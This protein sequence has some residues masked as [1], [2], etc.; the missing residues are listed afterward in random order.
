MPISLLGKYERA[1]SGTRIVVLKSNNVIKVNMIRYGEEW[2]VIK[3][4][5]RIIPVA[6][7]LEFTMCHRYVRC[8]IHVS[9][10]IANVAS[11]WSDLCMQ[12][13]NARGGEHD[14]RTVL[15]RSVGS[16]WICHHNTNKYAAIRYTYRYIYLVYMYV[17]GGKV[18]GPQSSANR[19]CER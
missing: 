18:N 17:H 1:N 10:D 5:A 11:E 4:N 7:Y 16:T 2:R 6:K 9:A 8:A 13:N 15:N 3:Y 19:S 12:N 14:G